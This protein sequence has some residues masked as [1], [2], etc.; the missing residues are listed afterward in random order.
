MARFMEDIT[1]SNITM[2]DIGNSP[3]FIRLGE[4]NR[5]PAGTVIGTAKRI[6]IE[7]I[8]AH[9]VTAESGILIVGLVGHPIEDLSLS[10]IFIDFVGG[11]TEEQG[12]RVVPEFADS[13]PEPSRWG[14]LPSSGLFARHV[15]NF[16][17]GSCRIP[18]CQGRHAPGDVLGRRIGRPVGGP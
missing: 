16:S 5:G 14:I 1:I 10:N 13:Y 7:N 2:R 18:L 6:K 9:N 11:G 12:Q 3:I 8:V 4:R 15:T 17:D